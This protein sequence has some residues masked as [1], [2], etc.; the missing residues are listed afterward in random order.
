MDF[1]KV[2]IVG[3]LTRDPEVRATTGGQSVAT[4]SV[5]TGRTYTNKAGEKQ[6]K[7][8]FHNVVVWGR[9]AEICGQYLVKGQEV[10]FEGRLETRTWEAQDGQ[11]R[12][13]TEIV[14]ENMQLGSKSRG[15]APSEGGYKPSPKS[16]PTPEAPADEEE[17]KIEDIPF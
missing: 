16:A 10:L 11:K 3:R 8:E 7:T 17:I 15:G 2:I 12:T 13:R 6:E 14:A 9:L 5:A 1:N 4:V